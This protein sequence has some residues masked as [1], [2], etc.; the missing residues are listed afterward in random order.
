VVVPLD[1]TGSSHCRQS[2]PDILAELV[3]VENGDLGADILYYLIVPGPAW[4]AVDFF[5]RAEHSAWKSV[6]ESP[7]IV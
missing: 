6:F 3:A 7:S 4:G 2:V 5:I 1:N